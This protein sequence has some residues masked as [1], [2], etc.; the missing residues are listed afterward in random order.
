MPTRARH[1]ATRDTIRRFCLCSGP[2]RLS[3]RVL[4]PAGSNLC[5]SVCLVRPGVRTHP[6]PPKA[7][8]RVHFHERTFLLSILSRI[9]NL[10]QLLAVVLQPPVRRSFTCATYE[11]KRQKLKKLKNE[12]NERGM[13]GSRDRAEMRS[14]RVYEADRRMGFR[15]N[16]AAGRCESS[17]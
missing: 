14:A 6:N 11:I 1:R 12:G 13:R 2:R 5:V 9:T 4:I 7:D 16:I 17:R 15:R 8:A 10:P 3:I